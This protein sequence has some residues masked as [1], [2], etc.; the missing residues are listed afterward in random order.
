MVRIKDYSKAYA[1]VLGVIDYL[2]EEEYNKIPFEELE[3]FERN[4]DEEY[5]FKYD[6][7]KSLHEQRISREAKAI[8][9]WLFQKYFATPEENEKIN[10]KL[11]ENEE[12]YQEALRLEYNPDNLF[13]KEE[14]KT[15]KI[16][17]KQVPSVIE[18]KNI[19]QRIID[20]IKNIFA[21]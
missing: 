11:S 4:Q 18:K 13:P 3:F 19:F 17:E 21:K 8:L 7:E 1:E 15:E 6:P 12:K 20:K 5:D 14:E 16:E 2:S 10:Q 9:V